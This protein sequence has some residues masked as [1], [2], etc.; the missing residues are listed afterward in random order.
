MS[1]YATKK[2]LNDST[3]VDTFYLA[4]K[5]DFISLKGEVDKLGINKMVNVPTSLNSL[6]VDYKSRLFRYW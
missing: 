3:G 6:A 2:E 4:A 5:K 1:K